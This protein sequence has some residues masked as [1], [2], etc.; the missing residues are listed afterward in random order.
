MKWL[1][2]PFSFTLTASAM[3][4]DP[5]CGAEN[6]ERALWN[7]PIGV[8]AAETITTSCKLRVTVFENIFSEKSF[9][10]TFSKINFRMWVQIARCQD[11]PT[12]TVLRGWW[13]HFRLRLDPPPFF[14]KSFCFL[15]WRLIASK[16]SAPSRAEWIADVSPKWVKLFNSLCFILFFSKL[17]KYHFQT[18]HTSSP[19][20]PF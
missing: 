12:L 2:K 10:V 11:T 19:D 7:D 5:N 20:H 15:F 17:L 14:L 4:I 1:R 18:L 3:A 6:E 16:T 8:L 9:N 13:T